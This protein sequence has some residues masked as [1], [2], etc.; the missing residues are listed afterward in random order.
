[1]SSII[2]HAEE[3]RLFNP[4]A[5]VNMDDYYIVATGTPEPSEDEGDNDDEDNAS[6]QNDNMEITSDA[7]NASEN[8]TRSMRPIEE[9]TSSYTVEAVLEGLR[10]K[11]DAKKA[12]ALMILN[13]LLARRPRMATDA[14]LMVRFWTAIPPKFL[15]RLLSASSN[16]K[17]D[18][19]NKEMSIELAV[20]ILYTFSGLL[21]EEEL[22]GER[23][24]GRIKGLLR[25]LPSR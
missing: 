21:P 20:G 6:E 12:A 14:D 1:M 13:H 17:L 19:A 24:L 22:E 15:D 9:G 23:M 18:P 11:S 10:A 2:D 4:N 5:A 16:P 7:E 25:V 3:A 8:S